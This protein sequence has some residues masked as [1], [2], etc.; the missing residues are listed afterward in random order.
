MDP[1]V[2]G[3]ASRWTDNKIIKTFG[4]KSIAPIYAKKGDVVIANTIAFHKGT[5]PILKNRYVIIANYGLH[6]DYVN[7]EKDAL[8]EI[9]KKEFKKLK[10]IEEKR[11][12]KFLKKI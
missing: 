5:K 2:P 11:V 1:S 12:L 6:P 9:K 3:R 4:R 8:P 10:K 7:G